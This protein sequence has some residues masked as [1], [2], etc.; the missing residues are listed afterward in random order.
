MYVYVYL[1]P[2]NL[3][4]AIAD[5]EN[6]LTRLHLKEFQ[7]LQNTKSSYFDLLHLDRL[8]GLK[9]ICRFRFHV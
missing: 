1:F 5:L 3:K 2:F 6:K 9:L 7:R 8:I 4:Q